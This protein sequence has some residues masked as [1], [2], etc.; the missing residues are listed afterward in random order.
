MNSNPNKV[1]TNCKHLNLYYNVI[2][3]KLMFYC[4]HNLWWPK[5]SCKKKIELKKEEINQQVANFKYA[6]WM[7]N[8]F[9]T[10]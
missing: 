1:C 6:I 9:Q 10:K 5:E 3:D 8:K 2:R 4:E 7:K